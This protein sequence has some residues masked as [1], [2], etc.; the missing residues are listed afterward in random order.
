MEIIK[1]DRCRD[2]CGDSILSVIHFVGDITNLNY[3]IPQFSQPFVLFRSSPENL[4]L[5]PTMAQWM[6]LQ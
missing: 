2:I 4:Y 6:H 3:A 5:D 1:M